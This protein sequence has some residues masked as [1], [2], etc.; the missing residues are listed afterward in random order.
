MINILCD[1]LL[2]G[3]IGIAVYILY[4]TRNYR[5]GVVVSN[6]E[7]KTLSDGSGGLETSF[8]SSRAND[9]CVADRA[10]QPFESEVDRKSVV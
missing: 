10:V 6:D 5:F 2:V 9:I 7:N 3:F 8:G 4:R 1:L